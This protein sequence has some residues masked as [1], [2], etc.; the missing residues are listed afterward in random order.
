MDRIP[1]T[2]YICWRLFGCSQFYNTVVC[3]L[4]AVDVRRIACRSK[5]SCELDS[6]QA[7]GSKF[8]LFVVPNALVACCR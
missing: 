4:T 8:Y 2:T 1:K 7:I 3:L 6:E 5:A